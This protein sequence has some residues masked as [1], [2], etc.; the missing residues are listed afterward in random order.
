VQV[1]PPH[2]PTATA[3]AIRRWRSGEGREGLE[4]TRAW[5]REDYA[6][7]TYVAR[8][9]QLYTDVVDTAARAD[10]GAPA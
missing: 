4:S 1:V 9:E 2:D 5:L 8:M 6:L 7:E 3:E 10:A